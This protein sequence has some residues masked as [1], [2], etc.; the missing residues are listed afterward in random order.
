MIDHWQFFLIKLKNIRKLS[1][2]RCDFEEKKKQQNQKIP[3]YT[4]KI[5]G[6]EKMNERNY[7]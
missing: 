3:M 6:T 1:R 7:G 2:Y 4:E 5:I